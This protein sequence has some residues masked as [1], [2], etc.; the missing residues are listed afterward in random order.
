MDGK[1]EMNVYCEEFANKLAAKESKVWIVSSKSYSKRSNLN[2]DIACW[3]GWEV[4]LRTPKKDILIVML[5]RKYIPQLLDHFVDFAVV[6]E[7]AEKNLN[8]SAKISKIEKQLS[9]P[10]FVVTFGR[11]VADSFY[12]NFTT[13]TIYDSFI[14]ARVDSLYYDEETMNYLQFRLPTKI[15][16][17]YMLYGVAFLSSIVENL[18]KLELDQNILPIDIDMIPQMLNE[19]Y[20]DEPEIEEIVEETDPFYHPPP[21]FKVKQALEEKLV[22]GKKKNQA[23]QQYAAWASKVSKFFA[24]CV[25]GGLLNFFFTLNTLVESYIKHSKE[26]GSEILNQIILYLLHFRSEKECFDEESPLATQIYDM[27]YSKENYV[28]NEKV[29]INLIEIGYFQKELGG[30]D[31]P[32]LYSKFLTYMLETSTNPFIKYAICR[33]I[34]KDQNE[35]KQSSVNVDINLVEVKALIKPILR[36]YQG[37]NSKLATLAAISLASLCS[38]TREIKQFIMQ[39]G[40]EIIIMHL[41]PKDEDLLKYTLQLLEYLMLVNQNVQTFLSKGVDKKIFEIL[42][43]SSIPGVLYSDEVLTLACQVL[44]LIVSNVEEYRRLIIDKIDLIMGLFDLERTRP[45]SEALVAEIMNLFLI[46]M[47]DKDQGAIDFIGFRC[48]DVFF[49]KL[50]DDFFKTKDMQNRILTFL[51][52]FKESEEIMIKIRLA[53]IVPKIREFMRDQKTKATALLKEIEGPQA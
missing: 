9:D 11:K 32:L 48:L 27:I 24:Y 2:Q 37:D 51:L 5:R 52:R 20:K 19:K 49:K 50:R 31:K 25:D 14:Q 3:Q 15:K 29:M 6:I 16:P 28:Y 43:G 18:K 13:L 41:S 12:A 23:D 53:N 26:Q 1:E 30:S 10:L 44:G 38:K 42:E 40:D 46:K 36:L 45:I 21:W 33:Q 39:E 22:G 7:G 8:P 34:I 47:S 4:H 35:K 17:N